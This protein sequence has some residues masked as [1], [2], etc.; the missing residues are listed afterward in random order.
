MISSLKNEFGY[1]V[2]LWIHPFVNLECTSWNYVAI[3]PIS[4][5]IKDK[6]KSGLGNLPGLTTWWQGVIACY[7]DFTNLNAV[8]WWSQRLEQN[9]IHNKMSKI[10]S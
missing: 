10:S 9:S 4:Y 7:I 5:C 6:K 2:T 1:R 8:E 3:P